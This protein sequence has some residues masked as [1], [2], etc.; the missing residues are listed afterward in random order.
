MSDDFLKSKRKRSDD[1][2]ISRIA[3]SKKICDVF[4]L[5]LNQVRQCVPL[6]NVQSCGG[7]YQIFRSH[8]YKCLT[9]FLNS[10]K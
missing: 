10:K 8:F 3:T 4:I 2:N 6:F 7:V 5:I 9:F 1:S